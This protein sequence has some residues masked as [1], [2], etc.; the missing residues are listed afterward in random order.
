MKTEKKIG[1]LLIVGALGVLIPYIVLTIIF[2]YP[3][4]LRKETGLILAKFHEGGTRLILTWWAFAVLGIPLLIA[5]SLL[6]QKLEQKL[7]FIRWTTMLGLVGLLVQMFGL[8][9]WSFVVP[10]LASRFVEGNEM[11]RE[12]SKVGFEILHQYAGVVMGEHI[13][14]LF[15]LAWTVLMNYAFSKLGL[16]SK[17]IIRL[18]YAASIIYLLAQLELF[19][20]VIPAVPVIDMA[21]LVGSTLWIIWL[22]VVG[23][24]MMKLNIDKVKTN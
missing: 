2:D 6:G 15:T 20:T 18:G 22:L 5:Y 23:V 8:L 9:R 7:S 3:V 17:W 4:I 14:Q 1:I 13:G 10:V 21:G 19:S 16:F 11:A 12:A 24:K